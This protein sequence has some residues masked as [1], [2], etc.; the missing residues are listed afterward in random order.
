[1]G[2]CASSVKRRQKQ[3]RERHKRRELKSAT[4]Y[5]N[6]HLSPVPFTVLR[7][8]RPQSLLT[9]LN[10]QSSSLLEP[11]VPRT[12]PSSL[13]QLCSPNTNTSM[14]SSSTTHVSP[15]IP[16]PKSRLPI[17]QPQSS[18]SGPI[19]PKYIPPAIGTTNPT[20]NTQ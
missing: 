5:D 11:I 15:R 3:H 8:Q 20:G 16:V 18:L 10:I 9:N 13:I 1:M 4:V 2:T 17:H 7:N 12:E 14:S 6:K 19:R